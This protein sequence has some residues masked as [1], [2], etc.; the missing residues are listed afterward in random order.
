MK[1]VTPLSEVVQPLRGVIFDVDGVT[2]N[3]MDHA[4]NWQKFV[5]D[6]MGDKSKNFD[7]YTDNWMNN[8]NKIYA[9]EGIKG[10]Y[11]KLS[12]VNWDNN[13]NTIWK[14]YNSYN[15]KNSVTTIKKNGIDMADVINE[16]YF[17][18]GAS[19][20][21][22]S[23]LRLGINT[24]KGRESLDGLLKKSGI[25]NCFDTIITY[26]DIL[27]ILVDGKIKQNQITAEN[28]E[29]LRKLIPPNM[30]EYI[31]KPNSLSSMLC[32]NAMGVSPNEIVVFEDTIN[33]V[34]AYKPVMTAPRPMSAYV[35][36]V[37]WGFVKD[38]RKLLDAGA[39]A[40]INCP[41]EIVSILENLSAFN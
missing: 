34:L 41:S 5:Y 15:A 11:D 8:Y 17:R 10:L 24:T 25:N 37:T 7:E 23:R 6:K 36:G 27:K 1:I 26:D 31:E 13:E 28:I 3:T 22:M 16:V 30:K 19:N 12:H 4:Y 32:A 21:R 39:D 35:V 33:G 38:E 9:N 14:E 29:V 20:Q 18:G 40:I 2:Y